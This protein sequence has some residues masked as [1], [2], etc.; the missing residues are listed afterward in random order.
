MKV[1]IKPNVIPDSAKN[2]T[3]QVI[4]AICLQLIS[5][6]AFAQKL[7]LHEKVDYLRVLIA[8]AAKADENNPCPLHKL[9]KTMLIAG[10]PIKL[11]KNFKYMAFVQFPEHSQ[12]HQLDE[13]YPLVIEINEEIHHKP[14]DKYL[15]EQIA[16][17]IFNNTRNMLKL[18]DV[19]SLVPA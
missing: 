10:R 2:I 3:L 19:A 14:K 9:V 6:F 15:A 12:L 16:A 18:L 13:N 4:E 17:N 8:M 11:G 5:V 1:I 7:E